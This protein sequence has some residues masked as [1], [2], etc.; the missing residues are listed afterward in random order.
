M[1]INIYG[2]LLRKASHNLAVHCILLETSS[3]NIKT[4][5]LWPLYEIK[6]QAFHNFT[7]NFRS[8]IETYLEPKVLI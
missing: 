1:L 8:N 5:K 7:Y 6:M 4:S 2:L 3:K